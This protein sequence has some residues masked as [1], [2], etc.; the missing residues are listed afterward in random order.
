VPTLGHRAVRYVMYI[1][2]LTEEE[3]VYILFTK[4]TNP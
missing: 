1:S 2:H 4:N 3:G